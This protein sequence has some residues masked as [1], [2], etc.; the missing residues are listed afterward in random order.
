[1][2]VYSAGLRVG[3]VVR[4]RAED[5]DSKRMPIHIKGSQGRRDKY[6]MLSET[7]LEVLRQC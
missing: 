2:L 4:L 7:T 6:T 3:E 1:M 5:I